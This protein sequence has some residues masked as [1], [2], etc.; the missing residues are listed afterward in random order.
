MVC[1]LFTE[2]GDRELCK[3]LPAESTDL[4]FVQFLARDIVAESLE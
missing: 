4:Q 2:C 1:I 3:G